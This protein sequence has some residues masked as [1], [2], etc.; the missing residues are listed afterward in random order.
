MTEVCVDTVGF[1][2]EVDDLG[3]N[4]L[5]MSLLAVRWFWLAKLRPRLT[6]RSQEFKVWV[7]EVEKKLMLWLRR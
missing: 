5:R 2:E 3:E 1:V 7:D 6:R 4:Q